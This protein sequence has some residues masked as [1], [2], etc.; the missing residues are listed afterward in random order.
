MLFWE[1]MKK[2]IKQNVM[3]CKVCQRVKYEAASLE[4]LLQPLS[5]PTNI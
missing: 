1:G 4:G 2:N 5:I 3:E